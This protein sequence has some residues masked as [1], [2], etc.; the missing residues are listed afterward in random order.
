MFD[1]ENTLD[2]A[3]VE[4]LTRLA[5]AQEEQTKAIE[6][7]ASSMAQICD[8]FKDVSMAFEYNYALGKSRFRVAVRQE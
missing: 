1:T 3:F 5:V 7:L 8:V 2:K 4:S 6:Y